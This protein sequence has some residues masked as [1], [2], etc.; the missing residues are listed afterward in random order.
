M[1]T[2]G[3]A[4]DLLDPPRH[5]RRAPDPAAPPSARD[6]LRDL[7]AALASRAVPL[8]AALGTWR[9]EV[10]TLPFAQAVVAE[11][12]A[13][14]L[15]L[16]VTTLAVVTSSPEVAIPGTAIPRT[17]LIAA[18]A[19]LA[20]AVLVFALSTSSGGHLN[21]A[22]S[23]ALFLRGAISLPRLLA[24]ALA[25]VAGAT[26]GAAYTRS[27]NS[28]L[29]DAPRASACNRVNYGLG[30][31]TSM[32]TAFG[33]ELLATAILAWAVLASGDVGTLPATRRTGA[34]NPLSIGLAVFLAHLALVAVDGCSINP[35]R[36]FG[37]A[38]VAREWTDQWIFWVA[39]LSG[40]ALACV[41]YECFFF[42]RRSHPRAAVDA[43]LE[44]P[45]PT[46]ADSPASKGAHTRADSLS[47][48]MRMGTEAVGGALE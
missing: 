22:V 25:Q 45:V 41:S 43:L 9:A 48:D 14:T 37:T 6:I 23:F 36:S 5:A 35:A 26:A 4:V 19:G 42:G 27:L 33:A 28:Q 46:D 31:G 20:V 13:T 34:L 21:P 17:V 11:F 16:F 30:P 10:V 29:Y 39:P 1:T 3:A 32:W 38:A 24:Y 40:A 44:T 47:F 2:A 18:T 7:R 8:R 15:F 12:F